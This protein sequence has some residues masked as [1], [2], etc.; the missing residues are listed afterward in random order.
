MGTAGLNWYLSRR[1]RLMFNYSHGQVENSP[2]KG[3]LDIF[4][5]RLQID[6]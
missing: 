4:Q 3:D 2:T 6:F 5:S 1:L